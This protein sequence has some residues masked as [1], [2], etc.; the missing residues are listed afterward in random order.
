MQEI[1]V[2][3]QQLKSSLLNIRNILLSEPQLTP[4]RRSA[5]MVRC[6]D[7]YQEH[8]KTQ[9]VRLWYAK[10]KLDTALGTRMAGGVINRRQPIRTATGV[11]RANNSNLLKEY[12]CNLELTDKWA[13]GVLEKLTWSKRKGTTG[14]V[15][16]SPPVF[17]RRKIHFSEKYISI[18]F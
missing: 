2:L 14:K 11:V 13:R 3:L 15:D 7:R 5:M 6:L 10:K 1:L 4:G 17:S 8:W 16:S 9:P 18:G 12:G